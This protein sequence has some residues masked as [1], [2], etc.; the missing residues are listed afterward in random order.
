[1]SRKHGELPGWRRGAVFALGAGMNT[2]GFSLIELMVALTILAAVTGLVG[3]S[4]YESWRGAKIH[5]AEIE[6]EQLDE[7]VEMHKLS[8]KRYPI[9]LAEVELKKGLKR[10]PWDQDYDYTVPGEHNPRRFDVSSAGPDERRNTKDDI[11]N[12]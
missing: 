2:R 4:A 12:W 9:S 8:H 3:M 1:M 10:D 7:A 6:V 5:I 11:G